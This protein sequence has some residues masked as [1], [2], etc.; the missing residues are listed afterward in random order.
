[1]N[2]TLTTLAL[3]CCAGFTCSAGSLWDAVGDFFAN[4]PTNSWDVSGY[5]IYLNSG[6]LAEGVKPN[7]FGGGARLGYW[8]SPSVGAALDASY[9][10]SSWTFMSL[11][12][13]GRGTVNV[14]GYASLTLYATAGPGWNVRGPEQRLVAEAGG[15]AVLEIKALKW[16]QFFGEYQYITTS[17]PQERIIFGLVRRF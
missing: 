10:D 1:M 4:N 13:A 3:A 5:G 17:A 16:L 14:G 8:L 6:K 9:A 12:L 7:G 2:K 15:G 11:G